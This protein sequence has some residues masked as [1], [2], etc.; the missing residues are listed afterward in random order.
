MKRT[1]VLAA[2]VLTLAACAPNSGTVKDKSYHAPYSSWSTGYWSSGPCYSYNK[3]GGC[4]SRGPRQYHPGHY[5]YHPA[6]WHLRLVNGGDDGWRS[7]Y[8]GTWENCVVGDH[9][10]NESCVA[11]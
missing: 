5:V 7:V 6:S 11:Q 8:S 1:L 3:N 10:E 9:F 4:R 2:A